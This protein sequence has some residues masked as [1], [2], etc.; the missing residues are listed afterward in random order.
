MYIRSKVETSLDQFASSGNLLT[1]NFSFISMVLSIVTRSFL[2]KL[3]PCS[4]PYITIVPLCYIKLLLYVSFRAV[5]V[6]IIRTLS[7]TGLCWAS[8]R[9]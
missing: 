3:Y 2:V 6:E 4:S 7:G 1:F 8:G 5:P 9:R